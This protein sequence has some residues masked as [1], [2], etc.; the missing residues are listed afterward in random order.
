MSQQTSALTTAQLALLFKQ[1]Q[2]LEAAGLPAFEALTVLTKLSPELKNKLSLMQRQLKSGQAISLAGYRAGIFDETLKAILE[3]AESSG[4][5]ATVYRQLADYYAST[6]ARQ[7]KTKSRL[8]FPAAVLIIATFV[9]PLADLAAG[10]IGASAYLQMTVG[11]LIVLAAMIYFLLRLPNILR[12]V[13]A[14]GL[15]L[16]LPVIGQRIIDRQLNGFFFMLAML[17]EAGLAFAEALPKALKTIGNTA[18]QA[19]FSAALSMLGSGASVSRTLSE[20]TIIN[21]TLLGVL[22][23]SEQS[24]KLASGILHYTRLEAEELGRA[25]DEWAAWLPRIIYALIAGAIA[26]SILTGPMGTGAAPIP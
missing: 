7:R 3:A 23:S 2:Q 12:S 13:G 21:T 1:L 20:V 18:V 22:E 24:G 19:H 16:R 5:L 9:H 26:Y 11:R 17:L 8:V 4:R 14:G 15:L 10:H 25:D 6:S